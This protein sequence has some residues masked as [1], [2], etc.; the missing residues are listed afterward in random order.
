MVH[1]LAAAW[2]FVEESYHPSYALN[3]S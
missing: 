3:S 1:W 2:G